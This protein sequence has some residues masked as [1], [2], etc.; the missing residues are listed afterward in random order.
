MRHTHARLRVQ[1]VGPIITMFNGIPF[2]STQYAIFD[3]IECAFARQV[4]R[5]GDPPTT[6]GGRL[7]QPHPR[8][9]VHERPLRHRSSL[10]VS[11][12]VSGMALKGGAAATGSAS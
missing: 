1:Q 5:F 3:H 10:A 7:R 4:R 2:Q 12:R 9:L 8:H 11:T 6:P